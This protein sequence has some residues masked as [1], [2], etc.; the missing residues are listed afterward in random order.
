MTDDGAVVLSKIIELASKHRDDTG[1]ISWVGLTPALNEALKTSYTTK[2][3]KGR[4]QR[5]QQTQRTSSSAQGPPPKV[6][7]T[8]AVPAPKHNPKGTSPTTTS[9][10]ATGQ[11]KTKQTNARLGK[12]TSK[13][14]STIQGDTSTQSKA[15]QGQNG[16]AQDETPQTDSYMDRWS[17]ATTTPESTLQGAV[18]IQIDQRCIPWHDDTWN[19]IKQLEV[20]VVPSSTLHLLR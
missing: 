12:T 15:E 20:R 18:A 19:E 14:E 9:S 4:W 8:G 17:N 13:R 2:A 7:S 1:N 6:E 3:F 5:H 16:K 11:D 10:S